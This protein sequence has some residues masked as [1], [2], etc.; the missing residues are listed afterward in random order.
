MLNDIK[1]NTVPS[2]QRHVETFL[3]LRLQRL[4]PLHQTAKYKRGKKKERQRK[5][6]NSGVDDTS[7]NPIQTELFNECSAI[8]YGD[9][10]TEDREAIS[11]EFGMPSPSSAV[12]TVREVKSVLVF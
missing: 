11:E 6:K 7:S 8:S 9:N 5:K 12:E 3:Q 10:D 2:L 1:I 4:I